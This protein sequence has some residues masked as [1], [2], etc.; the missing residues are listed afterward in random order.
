MP[1]SWVDTEYSIHQAQHTP[2]TAYTEYSIHRV[3]HPPMIVCLPFI[4]MI[5]SWPLNV[6]SASGVHLYTI[7]RHHPACHESSKVKLPCHFP[8]CASHLTDEQGLSTQHAILRP[9][10]SSRP[11]SLNHGLQCKSPNSLDYSLQLCTIMASKFI[12]NVA[13]LWPPSI[14]WLTHLRPASLHYHH[15]QLY[16]QT[17]QITITECICK[18]T[19]SQPLSVSPTTLDSRLSMHLQTRSITA[20]QFASSWSPSASR[21]WLDPVL[22]V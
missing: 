2:S 12:S 8:T 21:H 7:D 11:I 10:P 18:F 1:W 3:L 15:H 5:M 19:R 14:S 6:A 16:L 9:P 22:G 20:C 17:R 13:R 4:F